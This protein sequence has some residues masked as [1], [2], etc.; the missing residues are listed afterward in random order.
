[1]CYAIR[2]STPGRC[3]RRPGCWRWYRWPAGSGPSSRDACSRTGRPCDVATRTGR[4][5]MN[6][7]HLH[8]LLNHIPTV[9]FG[10][11][12]AIFFLAA[13]VAIL[14]YVSGSDARAAVANT[15]GVSTALIDAHETAALTA[16]A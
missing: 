9:G 7:V 6:D 13:A 11:A 4:G 12:L 8:L 16:F 5:R 14:V 10:T 2:T 1:M 3:R 15:P